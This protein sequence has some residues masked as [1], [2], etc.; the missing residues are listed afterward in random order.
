MA[1][2]AAA[3]A[4][5]DAA[6]SDPPAEDE[7]HQQ[8][9]R[10]KKPSYVGVSRAVSGYSA[11]NRYDQ[12]SPDD[13]G[14]GGGYSRRKKSSLGVPEQ[15]PV[16]SPPQTL[17]HSSSPTP[18]DNM[19]QIT[20]PLQSGGGG[21]ANGHHR[22]VTD[23]AAASSSS[24]SYV[25]S[26]YMV[27][28]ATTSSSSSSAMKYHYSS[29]SSRGESPMSSDAALSPDAV[30]SSTASSSGGN[31]VA[32]QIERLYG[33]RA[34]SLRSPPSGGSSEDEELG[35]GRVISP[36]GGDG[37]GCSKQQP[38]RKVSGGFF[39]KRFGI[40]RQKDRHTA[41]DSRIVEERES[42]RNNNNNNGPLE[43]KQLKVP[44]VFRLLRPE[45][46]EQ[47]KSSSC[48]IPSDQTTT[49]SPTKKKLSPANSSASSSGATVARESVVAAR[50]R[51]IPIQRSDGVVVQTPPSNGNDSTPKSSRLLQEA[52]MPKRGSERIIPIVRETPKELPQPVKERSPSPP[53]P[54]ERIIP[55]QKSPERILDRR[56]SAE[57]DKAPAPVSISPRE[58]PSSPAR[59]QQGLG[60]PS[61]QVTSPGLVASTMRDAVADAVEEEEQAEEAAAAVVPL[62]GLSTV[63]EDTQEEEEAAAQQQEEVLEDPY[64]TVGGVHECAPALS[65][66]MEVEDESA[67]STGGSQVNLKALASRQTSAV[68][69]EAVGGAKAAAAQA[70]PVSVAA[71][72]AGDAS[73][74]AA[75]GEPVRDGHYFI[76]VRSGGE[77]M[78]DDYCRAALG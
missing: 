15:I 33:P 59:Q 75:G 49:P 17:D 44:A 16:S 19:R 1:A 56:P 46:R 6:A 39:S 23:R 77:K 65:T 8:P 66:I 28:A 50:E 34:Q 48:Q 5:A 11:F 30:A 78:D 27:S 76:K 9:E 72:A 69:G 67:S 58:K 52:T 29:P 71:A 22:D 60:S 73:S 7:Q 47:L 53:K 3:S 63:A 12:G 45:F 37:D 68:E 24:S 2:T 38:E 36:P 42:T 21:G 32:K 57:E 4:A 64:E 55:V 10:R 70:P 61:H 25:R 41:N 18:F 54:R 74:T 43:F 13:G 35:G 40:S 31:L 62:N 51:V 26:S 20:T 14:G